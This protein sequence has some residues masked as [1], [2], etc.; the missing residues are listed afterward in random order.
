MEV[1]RFRERQVTRQGLDAP[2]KEKENVRGRARAKARGD[3]LDHV[4]CARDL[5][6]LVTVFHTM[7]EKVSVLTHL[8]RDTRTLHRFEKLTLEGH[9]HD[10]ITGA[11]AFAVSVP[12]LQNFASYRF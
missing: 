11:G 3:V 2:A 12:S 5:T 1:D 6:R 10:W 4:S 9:K 8:A 7:Q